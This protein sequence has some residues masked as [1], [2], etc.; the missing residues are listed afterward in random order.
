[1]TAPVPNGHRPSNDRLQDSR[2]RSPTVR[3]VTVPEAAEI[4]GTTTDAVRSRMRRGKL[5]REAGEDGTVYVLLEG[6]EADS[7]DG[8]TT[9]EDGHENGTQTV[10]GGRPTVETVALWN[11]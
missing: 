8:P 10:G 7:H 4:L 6:D 2:G 3:R 1:M 5:R 11:P 9:A